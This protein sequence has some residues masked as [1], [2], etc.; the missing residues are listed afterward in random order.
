MK[1]ILRSLLV[2]LLSVAMMMPNADILIAYALS[3]P[4]DRSE[5]TVPEEL[6][7]GNSWYFIHENTYQVSEKSGEKLYIPIQR[8]G[9]LSREG[10]VSLKLRAG[11]HDQ[12]D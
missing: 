1:R 12:P 11:S 7:D 4:F 9:D 8:T 2:L 5:L 3:V 10:D 6:Q